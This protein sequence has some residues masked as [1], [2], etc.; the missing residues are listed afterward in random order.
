MPGAQQW[1]EGPDEGRKGRTTESAVSLE[2]GGGQRAG[3]RFTA[4]EAVD[5]N[6]TCCHPS[7]ESRHLWQQLISWALLFLL[8][9]RKVSHTASPTSEED[10]S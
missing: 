2:R 1:L 8:C 6:T 10:L 5:G 9:P 3:G 4:P 7:R